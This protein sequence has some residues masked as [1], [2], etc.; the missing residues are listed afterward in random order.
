MIPGPKRI[1]FGNQPGFL[2]V[3]ETV[4]APAL[5]KVRPP[6]P[7]ADRIL[8]WRLLFMT[9]RAFSRGVLFLVGAG[10]AHRVS[11]SAE[12]YTLE[13]AQLLLLIARDAAFQ[14]CF[15]SNASLAF[16]RL[17]LPLFH[18]E[19]VLPLRHLAGL[20]AQQPSLGN[21]VH[22]L[23][24]PG[25]GFQLGCKLGALEVLV[26]PRAQHW[27]QSKTFAACVFVCLPWCR[28]WM[29]WYSSCSRACD[30]VVCLFMALHK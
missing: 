21:A 9:D 3:G 15:P 28:F 8:L 6:V 16:R 23:V 2:F 22:T 5:D 14:E 27:Q 1:L 24:A 26:A 29:Y 30:L 10:L 7:L 11:F 13:F 25:T 12:G 4:V 17:F 18:R 20:A 19:R